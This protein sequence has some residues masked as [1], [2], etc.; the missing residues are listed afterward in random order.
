MIQVLNI[1]HHKN[2]KDAP[3]GTAWSLSESI[4]AERD[5]VVVT[6]RAECNKIRD[7]NELGISS[8]RGGDVV[9]EHTVY[10]LGN[11]ERLEVTHRASDRGIF[12]RGVLELITILHDQNPLFYNPS[13][14]LRL[15][16]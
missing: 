10:F 14:L 8:I 5:M 6:S 9:G 13:E 12:A 4:C 3:S 16:R 1:S 2:K 15:L 11:G 7:K